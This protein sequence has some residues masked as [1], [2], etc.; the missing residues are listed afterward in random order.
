M[1]GNNHENYVFV[2]HAFGNAQF[3]D[4]PEAKL[5]PENK[6]PWTVQAALQT[7]AAAGNVGPDLNTYAK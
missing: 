7:N 1:A 3:S 5:K 4:L 6:V 2:M